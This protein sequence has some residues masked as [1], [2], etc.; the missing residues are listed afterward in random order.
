LECGDRASM[1]FAGKC[2]EPLPENHLYIQTIK[3]TKELLVLI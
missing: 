2:C 3:L 1:G